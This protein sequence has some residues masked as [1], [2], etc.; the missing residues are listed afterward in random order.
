MN[1][2]KLNSPAPKLL[3]RQQAEERY[4]MSWNTLVKAAR[5]AGAL[6]HYGRSV[7]FNATIMD[8]FFDGLSGAE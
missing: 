2:K 4:N 7:F 5:E 8:T 3:K 1:A 6:V